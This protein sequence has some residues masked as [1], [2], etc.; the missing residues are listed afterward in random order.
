MIHIRKRIYT[1]NKNELSLL[2][3][4]PIVENQYQKIEESLFLK[5]I[6][7]YL[8]KD[9]WELLIALEVLNISVAKLSEIYNVSVQAIYQKKKRIQHKIK[10]IYLS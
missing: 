9:E 4:E 3:K 8:K 10:T 6:K 1:R 7:S 2:D 5:S